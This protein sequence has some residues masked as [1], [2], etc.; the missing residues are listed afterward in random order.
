MDCALQLQHYASSL[1]HPIDGL[2]MRGVDERKYRHSLGET[3]H[4]PSLAIILLAV[5]SITDA[6]WK[7]PVSKR[8][9]H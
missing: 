4:L 8:E 9:V 6:P 7:W 3:I 1:G 5:C 2:S